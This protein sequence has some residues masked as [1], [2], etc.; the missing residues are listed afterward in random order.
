MSTVLPLTAADCL[1]HI[2]KGA[3]PGHYVQVRVVEPVT[4]NVLAYSS[5]MDELG[6]DAGIDASKSAASATS[7]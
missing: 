4:K 3:R 7:T 5:R 2:H 6:T 1:R